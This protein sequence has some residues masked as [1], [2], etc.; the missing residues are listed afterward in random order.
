[1]KQI[2]EAYPW[3]HR[4]K[5]HRDL[6]RRTLFVFPDAFSPSQLQAYHLFRILFLNL[7][8]LV[9]MARKKQCNNPRPPFQS[10]ETIQRLYKYVIL[11]L[12]PSLL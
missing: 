12:P 10:M 7:K 3:K 9:A 4:Q 1:M 11:L 2:A 5:C 6:P 8:I